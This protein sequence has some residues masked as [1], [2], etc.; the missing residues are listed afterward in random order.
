MYLILASLNMCACCCVPCG[1]GVMCPA[2]YFLFSGIPTMTAIILTG[3]RLK[4]E[5]GDLC[6]EQEQAYG[7]AEDG[8]DL[9]FSSDADTM[10]KLW[11]A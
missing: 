3:Y 9:T 10:R 5:G 7:T 6:S 8:T 1:P 2:C 11:I 4:N